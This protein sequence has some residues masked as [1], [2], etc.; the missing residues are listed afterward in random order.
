MGDFTAKNHRKTTRTKGGG[1]GWGWGKAIS[2]SLTVTA[3]YKVNRKAMIRNEYNHILHPA[4]NI[5]RER[6]THTYGTPQLSH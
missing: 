6:R 3:D 1:W 2:Y 4:L 5:K